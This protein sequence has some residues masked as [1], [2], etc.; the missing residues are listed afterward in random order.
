[1]KYSAVLFDLDGTLLYTLEDIAAALN[2]ALAGRGM[3]PRTLEEVRAF[4]GNG[5]ARLVERA[6]PQGCGAEETAR[7][8]SDYRA[9]Y[10]SNCDV[11]TR[12]Y[13]EIPEL[14]RGLSGAGYRLAVVS[15]KPDGAVKAL[16]EAHFPG[17]FGVAVGEGPLV[18]RKPAPDTLLAALGKMGAGPAEA[19]YVGDSEVDIATAANAGLR[20]VSA[21]WGFRT[22]RQL[23]EAGAA[24]LI[25]SPLELA[26]LLKL[27]I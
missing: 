24:E 8:L 27:R 14:L 20:C 9:D 12:P 22:R 6:V 13:P 18:R 1:M 19:V 23:E 7:V 16:V 25:S 5:S 2:R 11:R 26:G 15:N 3:P 4:V 10:D 17:M 21:L